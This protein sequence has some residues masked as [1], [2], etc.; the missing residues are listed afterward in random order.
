MNDGLHRVRLSRG[1]TLVE[2]MATVAI[3]GILM[4]VA[5]ASSRPLATQART[6]TRELIVEL[7]RVRMSAITGSRC[8]RIS[9]TAGQLVTQWADVDHDCTIPSCSGC[10]SFLTERRYPAPPAVAIY[11]VSANDCSADP[12][13]I[14][15]VTP[16]PG[17]ATLMFRPDGSTDQ[18]VCF[19]VATRTEDTRA[20]D[21]KEVFRVIQATG[22]V[23][24]SQWP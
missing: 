7:Q 13:P 4:A 19:Y 16:F 22:K 9:V 2:L 6:Y 15:P 11:D 23:A 20:I 1:L 12:A 8:Y 5:L 24:S 18:T 21:G 14:A 3:I 10:T 17:T